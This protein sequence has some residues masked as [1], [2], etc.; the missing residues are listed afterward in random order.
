MVT[1]DAA[2]TSNGF[3]WF[4]AEVENVCDFVG[5]WMCFPCSRAAV[6]GRCRWDVTT[7]RP[8]A[9]RSLKNQRTPN[10]IRSSFTP[11]GNRSQM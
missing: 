6:T 3:H 10:G 5:S 11:P 7:G 4:Y 9:P 2:Q 1:K 8:H